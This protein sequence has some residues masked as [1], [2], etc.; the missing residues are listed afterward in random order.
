MDVDASAALASQERR[1]DAALA[2]QV[3]GDFCRAIECYDTILCEHPGDWDVAH[4]RAT[5]FFQLGA[6]DEACTAFR[7]LLDSPAA[8]SPGFWTNLGLL[9]AS[10]CAADTSSQWR[11]K[12]DAYRRFR[13]YAMPPF[14]PM[15]DMPSVSVV[16][17]AYLH[18]PWVGEAMTSVFG[19]T[20]LPVEL[21]VIDDGSGD[22]TLERARQAMENAPIPVRLITRENRGVAATL[23][24]GIALARGEFIQL[25]H[26]DDRLRPRRIEAMLGALLGSDAEWGFA[27]VAPIDRSGQPCARAADARAAA[28]VALQDGI[29]MAPTPGLS[30]LR[31][32]PAISGGNLMF[33]KRLWETLGGFRDYR[34]TRDWEFCLRAALA[35]E[36]VLV[37]EPLYEYR[38]HAGNTIS[39]A[40]SG[41][42]DERGRMLA[43]FVEYAN[44]RPAWG[45]PFAPTLGNWGDGMLAVLGATGLLRHVPRAALERALSTGS[46]HGASA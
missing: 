9:L 5:C 16:M 43:S 24:D 26:P 8:R 33:R 22:A 25:L 7:Q 10:V 38:V 21:I 23:N 31:G 30:M 32:N 11:D 15:T 41:M 40:D 19:Q 44:S 3:R 4:M 6:M 46:R 12:L 39:E 13:P 14:V 28:V 45:N 42:R 34:Y 20:R 17:P 27:R 36:P 37:S 29:M 35:C 1:R 18:A 2:L